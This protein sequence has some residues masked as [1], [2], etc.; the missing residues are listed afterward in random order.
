VGP[1]RPS[2]IAFPRFCKIPET[3]LVIGITKDCD[4][5]HETVAALLR[6]VRAAWP[7]GKDL[8]H[9]PLAKG[10]GRP[11][12]LVLGSSPHRAALA[13]SAA[14]GNLQV[15]A[16]SLAIDQYRAGVD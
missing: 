7:E 5:S 3:G 14:L 13:I 9:T 8:G 6:K 15:E 2:I 12:A 10:A 11:H 16:N 1:R 4:L